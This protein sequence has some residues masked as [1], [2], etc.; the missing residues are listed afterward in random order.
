M[1]KS[2]SAVGVILTFLLLLSY[3]ISYAGWVINEKSTDAFGNNSVQTTFIEGNLIRHETVSSIAIIDLEK[4]EVTIIFSQYRVFW[5]GTTAELKRS[6]VEAYDKQIEEM[7]IGLPTSVV[8]EL[9]SIYLGIRAQMLDTTLRF[10]DADID[11]IE[12]DISDLILDYN[13]NKYDIIVD[14]TLT[15]SI[16][17]TTE[18]KPY[19]EVNIQNML[20]FLKQMN[21]ISGGNVSQTSKYL[22]LMNNG[23]LLKSVEYRSD[24]VFQTVEVTNVREIHIPAEFFKPP[25][26]YRQA[27]FSDILNLMPIVSEE[28]ENW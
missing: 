8:K 3:F 15:E 18:I 27:T 21:S 10:K 16:W 17:H 26:G 19:N 7:M 9:D 24:T 4:K 13:C 12:T 2:S 1:L 5:K 22:E 20:A 6:T 23:L 11:V 25:P 14:S 28:L